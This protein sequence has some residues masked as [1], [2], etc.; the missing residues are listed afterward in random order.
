MASKK[1]GSARSSSSS[2]AGWI[3][4]GVAVVALGVGGYLL[5]RRRSTPQQTPLAPG[6]DLATQDLQGRLNMVGAQLLANGLWTVQTASALQQY[7]AAAGFSATQIA[8]LLANHAPAA[9]AAVTSDAP[10]VG[11]VINIVGQT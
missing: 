4:G 6:G 10:Y 1:R 2:S 8:G 9:I 5:Y 3:V 7:G 11:A